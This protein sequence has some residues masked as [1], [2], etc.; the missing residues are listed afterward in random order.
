MRG[1]A[2]IG[3][4][5]LI[6]AEWIGRIVLVAAVI[7]RDSPA[8]AHL[9]A[10]RALRVGVEAAVGAAAAHHLEAAVPGVG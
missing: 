1:A 7:D 2:G 3:V 5:V 9:D 10:G 4:V 6:G 8:L